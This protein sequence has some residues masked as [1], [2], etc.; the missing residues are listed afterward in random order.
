MVEDFSFQFG[1]IYKHTTARNNIRI[2][3]NPIR[4]DQLD[5][6]DNAKVKCLGN[7]LWWREERG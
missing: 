5:L 4:G 7:D 3:I 1:Q 6:V 2:C